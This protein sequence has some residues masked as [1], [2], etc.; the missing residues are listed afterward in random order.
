MD[1]IGEKD[2]K[3]PYPHLRPPAAKK[4]NTDHSICAVPIAL[5]YYTIMII[6]SP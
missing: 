1:S 3:T 4:M 6:L 2:V 5:Y